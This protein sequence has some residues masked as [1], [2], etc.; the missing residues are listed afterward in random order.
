MPADRLTVISPH[1]LAG[2]VLAVLAGADLDSTA[3]NNAISTADLEDA[4]HAYQAAGL[5]ALERRHEQSWC[6]VRVHFADWPAAEAVA[7]TVLGPALDR[8]Q[9]AGAIAGWWFLRKHPCWRLRLY[10]ADVTAVDHALDE[11]TAKAAIGRWWPAVYEPETAAFG[12]PSGIA[13]V[14][15]LF[16]ADSN[17]VL[18]YVRHEAPGLGRRELSIVL[19]GGLL[20]AAGLDTFECGDVFDRVARLRPAPTG[21]DSARVAQ[22]APNVRMLLSIADVPDNELFCPGGQLAHAKGWLDAFQAAGSQLADAAARGQLDRGLRALLTHVL[23][24]HWNRFGLSD[25]SQGVLARAASTGLL[26]VD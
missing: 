11:L 15:D 5:A 3:A 19:I 17:G 26:P 12:G 8:L 22:M 20:R 9:A 10:D 24:F 4:V 21:T 6:E 13:A 16:C 7:A 1:E 25:V 23:I 2:C 18:E 14:H